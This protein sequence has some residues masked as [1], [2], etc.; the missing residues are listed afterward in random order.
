[1][2]SPELYGTSS[3]RVIKSAS[4]AERSSS[5]GDV[6]LS[7]DRAV[8]RMFRLL[9]DNN[10]TGGDIEV[11]D[12]ETEDDEHMADE[13]LFSVL[14]R[15]KENRGENLSTDLEYAQK[16]AAALGLDP[17]NYQ[18]FARVGKELRAI[19]RNV[20]SEKSGKL[21]LSIVEE[22]ALPDLLKYK[23]KK[24]LI[25]LQASNK[26][27]AAQR[28]KSDDVGNEKWKT[29]GSRKQTDYDGE[30]EPR[31]NYGSHSKRDSRS[32]GGRGVAYGPRGGPGK[33]HRKLSYAGQGGKRGSISLR[34]DGKMSG[35]Q[36]KNENCTHFS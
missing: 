3:S 30:N 14:I 19:M 12:L 5:H 34:N 10:S 13:H 35:N 24:L 17:N 7:R 25:A 33:G 1:M 27:K 20:Y 26:N 2:Y 8:Q 28:G 6:S 11:Q 23:L 36:R 29:K 9:S 18:E 31:A 21:D 4:H 15:S 16:Y 22:S 32:G